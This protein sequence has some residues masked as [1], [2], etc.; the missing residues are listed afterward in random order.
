MNVASEA[1]SAYDFPAVE[2]LPDNPMMP[3]PFRKPDGTRVAALEFLKTRV[4][5]KIPTKGTAP[6][7][8]SR[9]N[10]YLRKSD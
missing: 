1:P 9:R 2:E 3:D 5:P 7:D 8:S 4:I 10:P 6:C